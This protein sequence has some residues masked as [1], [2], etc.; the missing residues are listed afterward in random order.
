[1]ETKLIE[2]DKSKII[3][4]PQGWVYSTVGKSLSIRNNLRFPISEEERERIKGEYPYYGPTKVQGYVDHYRVEGKFALIGEDGDHFLKFKDLQMTLLVEGKFNVN[5]HAHI[6]EGTDQCTTEWF[7]YFFAHRDLFSYLTRQGAGRY[8]LT[9]DALQRLPIQLPPLPQQRKIA[10]ILSTW[11]EAIQTAEQL[12]KAKQERK[13]GLM[14]QLLTGQKR[15]PGFSGEWK[16]YQI[17]DFIKESRIPLA[18]SD[19][20]KRITVKLNLKGIDKRDFKREE[21]E[22]ATVYY[23]RRKGQFIYGKQNLHKGAMG[24]IPEELDGFASS[25]DIPAFDFSDQADPAWF[26]AYMSQEKFFTDLEKIATGT[27]SKRIHPESLYKVKILAPSLNEQ[28]AIANVL[29]TADEEIRLAAAEVE[30]LKQQK[31]G[32]MQELLTGKTLVTA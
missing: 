19:P 16:S 27:G 14:Q 12:L 21:N 2:T 26:L 20:N 23:A 11:D 30:A 4:L 32:L 10:A 22:Q 18:Q 6:I 3:N 8:K 31:R 28:R 7:Y 15:L 13:R 1:M 29:N 25:Q 5:N 9:K 17:S 24:I